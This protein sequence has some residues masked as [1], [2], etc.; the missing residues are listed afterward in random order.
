[1]GH[2]AMPSYQFVINSITVLKVNKVCLCLNK[3]CSPVFLKAGNSTTRL[4]KS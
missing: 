3:R 2:F 4:F 1:M